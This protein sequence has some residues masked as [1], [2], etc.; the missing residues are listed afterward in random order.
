M[1]PIVQASDEDHEGEEGD[2]YGDNVRENIIEQFVQYQGASKEGHTRPDHR[3]Q[4]SVVG[5]LSALCCELLA[6][7]FDC[8]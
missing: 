3:Q 7:G 8:S 2:T 4:G 6:A 5:Q 1:T